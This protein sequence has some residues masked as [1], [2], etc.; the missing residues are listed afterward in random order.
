MRGGGRP[1]RVLHCPTTVG[2]HPPGLARAEREVGLES[3]CVAFRESPY[4]FEAD[5]V[6]FARGM[7]R[8]ER[9]RR[10]G[11]LLRRAMRNFDVIHCNFGASIMPQWM[12]G[13]GHGS[14]R[15]LFDAYARLLDTRDVG[16]L[17]RAGKAVVVTFQGDDARQGDGLGRDSELLREVEPGYYTP[18]G[19]A[20]KRRRIAR[21]A[22]SADRIFALNPD[23]LR[24]LPSRASFLPYGNLRLEEFARTFPP[25]GTREIPTV[26]HAPTH[27]GAKGTRSI[28]AAV[29]RLRDEGVK[30]DFVL[31][32]GMSYREARAV[33]EG[34]DLV[35]DQLLVGWYGSVGLEAMAFGTPAVAA[36]HDEDLAPVP[37]EMAAQLPV[38]RATPATIADVL[39]DWV[40]ARKPE[41]ADAGSRSRR[42]I[43]TWHDSRRIAEGL[44]EEYESILRARR[45]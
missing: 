11:Q 14:R 41:L 35:V 29:D 30:L 1:I 24:V 19:D 15:V 4:G 6:L 18:A 20:Q 10:R 17:R 44:K 8:L 43:E 28:V 40:T 39:R 37:A 25:P 3:R 34:A 31:V 33:Y 13:G 16:W 23:L 22:R 27:R 26:V 38:I 45:D 7:S 2:G 5:E 36:I 12:P 21:F 9:E 32:E 42:F